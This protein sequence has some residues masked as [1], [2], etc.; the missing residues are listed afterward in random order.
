MSKT[1]L[2][3]YQK[4][5]SDYVMQ[6]E[7]CVLAMAPNAGKTEV[8]IDVIGRYLK[9]N[10]NA[11]VLILPHST[12]VL[13]ANFFDRLKLNDVEFTY[14]DDLK[15][16]AQ[17]HLCIPANQHK[18]KAKYDFIIVDEAHENYLAP[19]VKSIIQKSKP[20]KQLLLTATPSKFI[21]EG[22]YDIFTIPL[23]E[24]PDEYFSKL[25]IE[26]ITSNYN[27]KQ[28]DYNESSEIKKGFNYTLEDT[29]KTIESVVLSLMDRLSSGLSAEEFNDPT[30]FTKVK[31]FFKNKIVDKLTWN[32]TFKNV[33][34]TLFVCNRQEQADLIYSIL[35]DNGV[36]VILSHSDNDKDS[37]NVVKFKNN[38]HDVL[39]VVNRCRI[40]YN[41]KDLVNIID[42]SGTRNIDLIY[43][44]MCRAIRGDQSANKYYLKVTTNDLVNMAADEICVNGA[45]MLSSREHLLKYN[46]K[47]FNDL[48]IPVLKVARTVVD[49]TNKRVNR[50][51]TDGP[52]RERR[53]IMPDIAHD[54]FKLLRDIKH[55]LNNTTSIY[56]ISTISEVKTKLGLIKERK[57]ITYEEILA[58]ARTPETVE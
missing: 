35:K 40:G 57:S 15:S 11:K 47:N 43:Q 13:L 48:K 45:L 12:N 29:K 30:L 8:A 22:G 6:S 46:G 28:T 50:N 49:T 41:D 14:S 1:I 20:S 17:V 56:K 25:N 38:E 9:A 10:P 58:I 16:D 19:R 2:R 36:D 51:T 23:D 4:E 55:D 42:M 32:S 27:W 5:A 34:K 18:I 24:L 7:K 31:Q 37:A 33:G 53:S 44:T 3:P 39:V 52:T 21:L 54:V 26:L